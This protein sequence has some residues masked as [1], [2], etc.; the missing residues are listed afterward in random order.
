MEREP[1][2]PLS[3]TA[4]AS[5]TSMSVIYLLILVFWT[6]HT[7]FDEAGLR[8]KYPGAFPPGGHYRGPARK[9]ASRDAGPDVLFLFA[10]EDLYTPGCAPRG[11]DRPVTPPRQVSPAQTEALDQ[12]AVAVDVHLGQVVQ[13][14]AATADHQQKTTAGVVVVL[15]LLEVLREIGDALAQQSHLRLGRAGVAVVQTVLTEDGLLLL[16]GQCH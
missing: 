1:N 7:R 10:A 12:R 3:I 4:V 13:Q 15:V 9:L 5:W 11:S 14:T 2:L 16:R 6:P 8:S